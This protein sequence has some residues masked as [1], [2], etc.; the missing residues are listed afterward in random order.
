MIEIIE[1]LPDNVVGIIVKGR[2]T[3]TDCA[4][5]LVPKLK[6]SLD[7]H[8]KLRLYH[9]IRSRFPG[10][11]WETIDLGLD[12]VPWERIAIVTDVASVRHTVQALRL[13]I[14]GDIRVFESSQMA[15]GLAWITARDARALDEATATGRRRRS[16]LSLPAAKAE[17][18]GS[19]SFRPAPQY[20]SDRTNPS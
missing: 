1:G 7:W 9:E 16:G 2:L 5:I 11:A 12:H 3:K 14:P 13:V 18:A 19:L 17:G 10:A 20:L 8:Y 4:E 15:Q 6:K